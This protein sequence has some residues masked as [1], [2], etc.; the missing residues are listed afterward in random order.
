MAVPAVDAQ[1]RD[2]VLVA[3]W[4]GLLDGFTATLI[5]AGVVEGQERADGAARDEDERGSLAKHPF[6]IEP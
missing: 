3:E 1:P 2:V 5:E 4:D 6:F